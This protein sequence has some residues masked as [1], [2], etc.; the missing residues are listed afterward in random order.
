MRKRKLRPV[1]EA[2]YR[3]ELLKSI[4]GPNPVIPSSNRYRVVLKDMR[5]PRGSVIEID[6]NLSKSDADRLLEQFTKLSWIPRRPGVYTIENVVLLVELDTK[7][8]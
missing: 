1:Q 7:E 5:K 4:V 6:D 8:E 3:A 2:K